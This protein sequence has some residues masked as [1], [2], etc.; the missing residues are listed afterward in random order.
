MKK[1]LL[2]LLLLMP[3]FV[4]HA[5]E[6]PAL[7]PADYSIVVHVQSSSLYELVINGFPRLFLRLAVLIDGKKYEL[8]DTSVRSAL[9]R[10]GDYKAKISHDETTRSFEYQRTY[11]F[12]MP[13]GETRQYIV[14]AETE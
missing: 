2:T 7:N 4:C 9:L 10:I 12:L 1:L 13:N 6:R 14:V 11:E 3:A 8:E 5:K